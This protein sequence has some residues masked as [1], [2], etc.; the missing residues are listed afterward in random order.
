MESSRV[1]QLQ[2]VDLPSRVWV[3]ALRYLNQFSNELFLISMLLLSMVDFMH[4][5]T[6]FHLAARDT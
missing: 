6:G 3:F 2:A 1:I 5:V 4:V